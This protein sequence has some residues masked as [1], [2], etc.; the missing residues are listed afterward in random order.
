M[1]LQVKAQL[2]QLFLDLTDTLVANLEELLVGN[3]DFQ[4]VSK[5]APSSLKDLNSK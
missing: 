4:R 1:E 5:M 3:Y 2:S